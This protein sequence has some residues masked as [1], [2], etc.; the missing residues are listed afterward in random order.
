MKFSEHWLRT[1]VDPPLTRGQLADALTMAGLEVE[2]VEAAAAEFDGVVVGEVLAVEPHPNADRLHVC[3]VNVGTAAPLDIV[4]GAPNV[5]PG[6]KVPAAL[7]G[8]HLP[9]TTIRPVKMRGVE[10]RG[11]L[12]SARELGLSD[13]HGGLLVLAQETPAGT[14]IR[15]HL[16]LD[17]RIF[18]L[19]LTPNRG[20]CLSVR[21]I[22]R[23]VAAITGAELSGLEIRPVSQA[24][25]DWLDV[26]VADTAACPRY[27]GRVIKTVNARAVTPPWMVQR[28]E[29]GGVRAI[30]ALVDITNYVMLELGQP[31]HAFDLAGIDSE[32]QV[33]FARAG[34]TLALLN[35]QTVELTPDLLVIADRS[36][37]LALGGIMGGSQS[38]VGEDTQD[39]FLESAFFAPDVI[40]GK[41]RELGFGSEA[42]HRF[43]RGVDFGATT[44][45]L[46]RATA[47][48]LEICGG[49]AGPVTEACGELPRRDPVT[50]RLARARRVLGIDIDAGKVADILRRLGLPFQ[51]NEENF[52]VTPPSYRFDLTIEEDLIEE[53]AR[54]YGYD[55]IPVTAPQAAVTMLPSPEGSR[56]VNDLRY[57]LVQ[58]DYQEIVSYSFVDE[59]WERDFCDNPAPVALRNPIA[60]QMSVMRSSLVGNLVNCL[61]FNLARRQ[62]R[63]RLF[64]VGRCF[65]NEGPDGQPLRIGGIAFG[66]AAPEQWGIKPRPIDFFDMKSDVEALCSPDTPHFEAA[67]HPAFHPGRCARILIA[68][69]AAGWI[70]ELHPRLQQKYDLPTAPMI[71]EMD[72]ESLTRRTVPAY[73]EISRFPQVRRDLAV[74]VEDEISVQTLLD[75]LQQGASPLISD[76]G[77]F[78]V[79][80]GKGVDAGKKS[81]AFRVLLQDTRKTLIDEEVDA[82]VS[83]IVRILSEQFGA[84]LRV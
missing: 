61:L 81:L 10:S 28:L 84:T 14:D 74:I 73:S 32:I 83:G 57:L 2:A 79:Y 78:D 13:D 1:F 47:L 58:R 12:C 38:A 6:I 35:E 33:R 8:A 4:C 40:K 77:L 27:C 15:H 56:E 3:K 75:A 71:F 34:E 55:N 37:P 29:R 26:R 41:S 36:R 9:N 44:R 11:M 76:I 54:I 52:S 43:E 39:I 49:R 51:Q 82:A 67:T 24:I 45:A 20:D 63:V 7:V 18:T 23:E 17:D 19:K 21:G 60:S 30:S 5:Q 64:E 80:R 46:E 66:A 69:G 70:G 50:M 62:A 59:Q 53:V 22:A 42:S 48:V 65:V 72:A 68:G 31:L 25:E 16:D